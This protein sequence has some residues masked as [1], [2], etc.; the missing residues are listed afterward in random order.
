MGRARPG[1]PHLKDRH[2]VKSTHLQLDRIVACPSSPGVRAARHAAFTGNPV[3]QQEVGQSL[4][5]INLQAVH[6]PV[7]VWNFSFS[8]HQYPYISSCDGCWSN[9]KKN[10]Q[11]YRV[12]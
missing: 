2:T 5:L 10:V 1:S 3:H 4:G 8:V 6:L 11:D 12:K 9:E 7:T